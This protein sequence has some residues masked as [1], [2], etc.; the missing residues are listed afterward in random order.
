MAGMLQQE[1]LWGYT[2]L[3]GL[4]TRQRM[5]L[6]LDQVRCA[7]AWLSSTSLVNP[8]SLLI[9]ENLKSDKPDAGDNF[10]HVW[11]MR[12][13]NT[14]KGREMENPHCD[15]MTTTAIITREMTVTISYYYSKVTL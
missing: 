4:T 15:A 7:G 1:A 10:Q 14:A 3:E 2:S 5:S 8:S 12:I 9:Y 13:T 6:Q 11:S